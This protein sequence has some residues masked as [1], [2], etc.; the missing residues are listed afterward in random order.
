MSSFISFIIYL[1][2]YLF[3]IV[4]LTLAFLLT[5]IYVIKIDWKKATN[6]ALIRVGKKDDCVVLLQEFNINDD[7]KKTIEE[8]NKKEILHTEFEIKENS[9]EI[10]E[11]NEIKLETEKG[12]V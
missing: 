2:I 6:E 11:N 8:E 9:I 5:T 10:E 12:I 7:K 3:I 1:F 4:G